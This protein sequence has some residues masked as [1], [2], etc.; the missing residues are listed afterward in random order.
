MIAD[1]VEM[2]RHN[3]NAVRTAHYPNDRR[4]YELCDYYGMLLY[5]EA[6]LETHGIW[7]LLTKEPI[8]E[9]AFMGPRR[10]YGG[11]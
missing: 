7:D 4:W 1:I 2:K 5:D 10:A 9:S 8:W 11:A 6:N 3:M